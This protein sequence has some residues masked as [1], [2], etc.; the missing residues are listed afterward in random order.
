MDD[1]TAALRQLLAG[2]LPPEDEKND[3]LFDALQ[4]QNDEMRAARLQAEAAARAE[5]NP[6][7]TPNM[8]K[9]LQDM[10][11]AADEHDALDRLFADL[12]RETGDG[13]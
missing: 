12:A 7:D 2:L 4:R 6:M 8:R 5:A 11:D 13:N 10:K 3:P 1:S 9:W